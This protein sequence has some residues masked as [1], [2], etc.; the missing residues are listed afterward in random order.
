MFWAAVFVRWFISLFF[1]VCE[2]PCSK[3]KLFCCFC[4]V[5]TPCTF[6]ELFNICAVVNV[7]WSVGKLAAHE[8]ETE[9]CACQRWVGPDARVTNHF[10]LQLDV[11]RYSDR[12]IICSRICCFHLSVIWSH[13]F[14]T[15]YIVALRSYWYYVSSLQPYTMFEFG[16]NSTSL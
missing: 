8:T 5:F 2:S 4:W 10:K 9:I 14:M 13:V 7:P 1:L 12:W 15:L 6:I 3:E 11:D 16:F